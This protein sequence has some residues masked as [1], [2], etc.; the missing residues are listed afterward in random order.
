MQSHDATCMPYP[1]VE[2]SDWSVTIIA[3]EADLLEKWLD[4]ARDV[5]VGR[6]LVCY[7]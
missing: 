6:D 4:L 3:P 1:S 2:I 5:E 7:L